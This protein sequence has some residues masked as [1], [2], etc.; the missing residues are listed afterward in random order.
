M[1]GTDAAKRTAMKICEECGLPMKVC[2]ALAT[3]RE[4]NKHFLLNRTTEALRSFE[5][6]EDWYNQYVAEFRAQR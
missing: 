1:N 3:Y 6:A 4:A 5:S 2:N